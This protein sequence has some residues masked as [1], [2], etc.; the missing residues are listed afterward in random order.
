MR[1]LPIPR[2]LGCHGMGVAEYSCMI[3]GGGRNVEASGLSLGV[4]GPRN[5][6]SLLRG[7]GT[8]EVGGLAV[9]ALG[10]LLY[11]DLSV[12]AIWRHN[13]RPDSP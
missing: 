3:G 12:R 9:R 7:A 6:K 8:N 4:E 2:R 13:V 5:E 11:I 1:A 10:V